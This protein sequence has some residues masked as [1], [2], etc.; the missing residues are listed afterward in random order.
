MAFAL[1]NFWEDIASCLI[2]EGW[3]IISISSRHT[4]IDHML[5]HKLN[6]S[7]FKKIEIVSSIFSIHNA[8]NQQQEKNCKKYKH[9]ETKQHASKKTNVSLKKSKKKLK[10]TTKQEFPLWGSRS[11]SDEES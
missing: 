5:G 6:L 1:I 7:K 9:M 3:R 8:S 10:N 2:K 4:R 11:K